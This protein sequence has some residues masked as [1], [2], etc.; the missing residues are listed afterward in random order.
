MNLSPI[1]SSRIASISLGLVALFV[2]YVGLQELRAVL[3]PL[4]L[5]VLVAFIFQPIVL[6]LKEKRVPTWLALVVVV[7]GSS[8]VLGGVGWIVYA[9]AQS[10]IGDYSSF[11][12]EIESTIRPVVVEVEAF[13]AG[14]AN[15]LGLEAEEGVLRQL[16]DLA[17]AALPVTA[18]LSDIA[19]IA[20]TTAIVLLFMMFI[21]AGTGQLEQKVEKAYPSE[22]AEKIIGAMNNISSQ[23]RQ[24][25]VA[26]TII[27]AAT[28]IL[29]FGV[30]RLTGVQYPV[31]WG[32]LAFVLNFVPNFGSIVAVILPTLWAFLQSQSAGMAADAI[33]SWVPFLALLL[34][35]LVQGV[36]GNIVDPKLIEARLK[37]SPLLVLMSLL[38]W[39]YL[40]GIVGVILAVPLTATIKIIFEN[41]DAFRPVAMLMGSA[42][43]GKH[44]RPPDPVAVEDVS[45]IAAASP[46]QET[47]AASAEEA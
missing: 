16:L 35:A 19:S 46:E 38:F 33:A 37:L 8:V 10:M 41:I 5:A 47:A 1:S 34:M 32:F 3:I 13:L 44:S 12:R 36:M 43:N 42:E 22:V 18:V 23:V 40:W 11:V 14:I 28:G 24:Y 15:R 20:G 17:V 2:L 7:V 4:V 9:S 39:G 30:L 31:F 26:K 27:S 29:I 25:L 21:L 45:G 6:F